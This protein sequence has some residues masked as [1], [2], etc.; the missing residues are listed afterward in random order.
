MMPYESRSTATEGAQH[1]RQRA[2]L[3][4]CTSPTGLVGAMAG[5]AGALRAWMLHCCQPL[6]TPGASL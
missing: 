1:L 4:L 2:S 3:P 6:R 5:L